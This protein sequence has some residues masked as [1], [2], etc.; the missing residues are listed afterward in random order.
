MM[1]RLLLCLLLLSACS[2]SDKES[3]QANTAEG[4]V[5]KEAEAKKKKVRTIKVSSVQSFVQDVALYEQVIGYIED[6]QLATVTAQVSGSVKRV[7]V[8][9][10]SQVKKG[11]VLVEIEPDDSKA[12]SQQAQAALSRLQ[13]E[14]KAQKRL[15]ARY[16][17]LGKEGF[18]SKQM[19]DAASDQLQVIE[20]SLHGARAQ[21]RQQNNQLRRTRIVAPFNGK[22]QTRYISQGDFVVVGKPLLLMIGQTSL[23]VRAPFPEQL[24]GVVKAGQKVNMRT[25]SGQHMQAVIHEMSPMVAKNGAFDAL[26]R[27]DQQTGWVAGGSVAVQVQMDFHAQAV[28]LPQSAVILRPAGE[29]VYQI[30]DHKAVAVLVSVGVRRDGWVEITKG[31]EA[32]VTVAGKGASFLS[33]GAAIKV[34]NP[35]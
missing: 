29:T 28:L 16:E 34:V 24:V 14:Y 2:D 31:L 25:P 15:L 30:K 17:K 27:V 3:S 12:G 6:E 5:Q 7:W 22:V 35:S 13:V 20:K 10:G 32:G 19:L 33:G 1:L 18:I 9:S 8:D 11:D 4:T 23:L 26:I 21:L